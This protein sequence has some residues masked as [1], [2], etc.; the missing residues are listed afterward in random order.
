MHFQMV[1]SKDGRLTVGKF[2]LLYTA[3]KAGSLTS[4]IG[5]EH[6]FSHNRKKQ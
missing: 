3:I 4:S 2:Q 5:K 6:I 1:L